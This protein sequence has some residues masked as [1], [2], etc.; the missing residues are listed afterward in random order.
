[1]HNGHVIAE[2]PLPSSTRKPGPGILANLLP[3]CDGCNGD[4]GRHELFEWIE[5]QGFVIEPH[6][7]GAFIMAKK[8]HLRFLAWWE[9]HGSPR[10][11]LDKEHPNCARLQGRLVGPGQVDSW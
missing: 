6:R 7:V 2:H 1:M 9:A 4:Q 8:E 3:L 5:Q 11:D 10:L